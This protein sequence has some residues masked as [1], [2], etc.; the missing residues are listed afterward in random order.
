MRTISQMRDE[1]KRLMQEISDVEGRC[2]I[3]DREPTDNEIDHMR[4][5][6]DTAKDLEVRAAL[7]ADVEKK[8]EALEKPVNEV[9][10]PDPEISDAVLVRYAAPVKPLEPAMIKTCPKSPLWESLGLALIFLDKSFTIFMPRVL[11]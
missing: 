2:Q 3:E 11:R 1:I 6:L 10:K 7:A 4:G 9:T 8:R 5:C